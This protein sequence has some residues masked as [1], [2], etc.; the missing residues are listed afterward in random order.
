MLA[1]DFLDVFVEALFWGGLE[2]GLG[3]RFGLLLWGCVGLGLFAAY[4]EADFGEVFDGGGYREPSLR[5][6]VAGCYH[7]LRGGVVVFV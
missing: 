1:E 3:V 6:E 4:K 2:E 5:G 7:E